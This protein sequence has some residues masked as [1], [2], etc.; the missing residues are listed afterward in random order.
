MPEV[1]VIGGG[2]IGC[3]C[4]W[5][6]ARRGAAVTLID[7][8]TPGRGAT[9]A[10][11]GVLSPFIEAPAESALQRLCV[12]GLAR[13]D[14]FMATLRQAT[15]TIVDYQRTG[16]IEVALNEAESS[17]L[18]QLAASLQVA[19]ISHDLRLGPDASRIDPSI[20]SAATAALVVP[21]HGFVSVPN[22]MEALLAAGAAHGVRLLQDV[23][24]SR[25]DRANSS[26]TSPRLRATTSS[27]TLDADHIVFAAGSW[28]G[29]IALDN[30]P[31]TPVRPVRGQLLH[32]AWKTAPLSRVIWGSRC[33]MVPWTNHTVLVGATVEEV[34]FA[35]ETTVAGIRTLLEAATE[36]VPDTA[37]AGFKEA[38]VGLRP[39]STDTLPLIGSSPDLPGLCYATGHYR[40]GILLAP[41]TAEM[42]AD[43]LLENRTHPLL[44]LASPD[45]WR[46]QTN[47]LA[48]VSDT[49]APAHETGH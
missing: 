34:G 45:R 30:L 32:L 18:E 11:A 27:G 17:Q 23:S 3:T 12:A 31:P 20:T 24:V 46:E 41:L 8:R 4:A 14:H 35:E 37:A 39:A 38:R 7:A 2:I 15:P 36:L 9:Q 40:N 1:I 47:G 43:H 44:H 16:T 49:P 5:E 10:S 25:I 19:G 21:S 29:Q 26:S 6:L 33:Y 22:L 28:S 48:T 13:W 42:V